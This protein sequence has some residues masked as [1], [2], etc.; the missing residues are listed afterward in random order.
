H[1]ID[2]LLLASLVEVESGFRIDA[3][4]PKGA[5]G[6]TQVMPA[7]AR[8]LGVANPERLLVDVELALDAGA[9]YLVHLHRRF[10]NDLPL[11]LAGYNSGPGAVI[12]HGGVPDYP[13]TRAYVRR[14]LAG[15]EM[16]RRAAEGMRR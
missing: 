16:R 4:S 3:V 8:E 5:L 11:L 12:R 15:Y 13:E 6:L 14:V 10:G 2:P 7:T 9:R 1:G